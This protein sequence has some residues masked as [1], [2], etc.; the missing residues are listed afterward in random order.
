MPQSMTGFGSAEKETFKV[1]IRS[2]NHRFLDV[3]MKVPQ[4]LGS[5]EIALRNRVKER[6]SRGRFDILVSTPAEGAHRI[7]VNT[8]LAKEIYN[9]LRSLKEEL[10]L[11]D[12]IR[13]ETLTGFR[14]L[15]LTEEAEYDIGPLYDAFDEAMD[16]LQDMRMREGKAITGDMLSRLERVEHMNGKILDLCP[17]VVNEHRER[18]RARLTD[19]F[20]EVKFDESRLLQEAA[21]MAEKSDVS[22]EITR[23]ASHILQMRKILSDGDTIGRKLEFLLQELNREV[24]TIA[25]KSGDYRISSITVEMKVEI[26]KM[27]EQSQNIQ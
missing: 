9:A 1:E 16:R 26:E 10:L 21:L 19:L 15:F 4:G 25:S 2:V 23:I 12:G 24:N 18:F 27:R 22:E 6:F 3:S 11:S 17:A 7:K 14:E 5:H 8:A 20:A 13:I